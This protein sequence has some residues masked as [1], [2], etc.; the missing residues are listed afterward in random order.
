MSCSVCQGYSSD[1]CPCCSDGARLIKCPDCNGTGKTP[2][3]AR[4]LATNKTKE[5]SKD[6][7]ENLPEETNEIDDRWV[8]HEE[9]GDRCPTCYGDGVIPE[10]Y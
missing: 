1:K 2:Y 6:E 3:I 4:N 10:D 5:V 9:G 8:R 7:W